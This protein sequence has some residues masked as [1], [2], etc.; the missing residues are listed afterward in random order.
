MAVTSSQQMLP[1]PSK[2]APCTALPHCLLVEAGRLA[3]PARGS[4]KVGGGDRPLLENLGNEFQEKCL[5][6]TV[7]LNHKPVSHP[8]FQ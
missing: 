3:R 1:A 7:L 4:R 2:A 5:S 8:R 6:P